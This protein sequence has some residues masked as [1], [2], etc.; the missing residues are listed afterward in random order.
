VKISIKLNG[1]FVI[2]LVIIFVLG[3]AGIML[4]KTLNENFQKYAGRILPS[5]IEAV[6][7]KSDMDQVLEYSRLYEM[8]GDAEHRW[9]AWSAIKSTERELTIYLLYSKGHVQRSK[10][11]QIDNGTRHFIKYSEAFLEVQNSNDPAKHEQFKNLMQI[12]AM[13]VS[14]EI[15]HLI[16]QDVVQTKDAE[17]VLKQKTSWSKIF[18]YTVFGLS[19]VIFVLAVVDMNVRVIRPIKKLTNIARVISG[20]NIDER[21]PDEMMASGNEISQLASSFDKMVRYLVEVSHSRDDLNIQMNEKIETE[22]EIKEQTDKLL[23]LKENFEQLPAEQTLV[24]SSFADDFLIPVNAILGYAELLEQ[25]MISPTKKDEFVGKIKEHSIQLSSLVQDLS[26]LAKLETDKLKIV[27]KQFP[28]RDLLEEVHK[29]AKREC[30]KKS[31]SIEIKVSTPANIDFDLLVTDRY[32]L[33]HVFYKLVDNAIIATQHG[34]I[35]IGFVLNDAATSVRFFVSDTGCGIDAGEFPT[36]FEKYKHVPP[37]KRMRNVGLGLAICKGIMQK[38]GGEIWLESEVLRGTTAY[39]EVA[40]P[41]KYD[42]TDVM[43]NSF[44]WRGKTFLIADDEEINKVLITEL[45]VKTNACLIFAEDGQCAIDLFKKQK[46]DLVL[47]DIK[48][49]EVDGYEATREIKLINPDV[50]VIA[51]TAYA[52]LH[53]REQCI[54]AG[55]DDYISKPFNISELLLTIHKNLK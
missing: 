32:R 49:P 38:L 16:D 1:V 39:V 31:K 37:S 48:M 50:P 45:L 51:N 11:R 44:D 24:F 12:Q 47:M 36:I 8:T 19:L 23:R 15:K 18:I 5:A 53:E 26:T 33:K 4:Q 28:V 52:L 54:E 25:D 22:E 41:P 46:F 17:V 7:L 14:Y 20:G 40:I 55:C 21:I 34:V 10:L 29:Y 42:V 43:V 9:K 30:N 6:K 2:L 27:K 3:V 35:S 13:K